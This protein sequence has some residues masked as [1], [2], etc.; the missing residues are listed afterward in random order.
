MT[1]KPIEGR[2]EGQA[3]DVEQLAR[4][5]QLALSEDAVDAIRGDL[6]RIVA[7]VDAMQSFD[8]DGV[9]PL[10]HPLGGAARLRPDEAGPALEPASYQVNAPET[11][12]DLYLVPRVVE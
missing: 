12:D 7:M 9:M 8:T 2:S 4:L 10:A 1:N 3:I 11:A 5:A 6:Q